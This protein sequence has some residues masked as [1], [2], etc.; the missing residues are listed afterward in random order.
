MIPV[1]QNYLTCVFLYSIYE[2]AQ[3]FLS[4]LNNCICSQVVLKEGP[5]MEGEIK[6][7]L[8]DLVN[9]LK[10]DLLVSYMICVSQFNDSVKQ[11][12]VSMS[13]V[14]KNKNIFI[15]ATCSSGFWN[16]YVVD[17]VMT[18]YPVREQRRDDFN[19]TFTLPDGVTCKAYKISDG[20]VKNPCGL[21]RNLFGLSP[22]LDA[23]ETAPEYRYGNCAEAESLSH[24][25]N[26]NAE[27][28]PSLR[29]TLN[30]REEVITH[31]QEVLNQ[32]LKSVHFEWNNEFYE[33]EYYM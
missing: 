5:A 4:P 11:Y 17:A 14:K 18:Y 3:V 9:S 2:K 12:G 6:E 13:N 16:N 30:D 26:K 7:S 8:K 21:C 19:G 15:G 23:D 20:T 27:I 33:P 31:V 1:R 24:L 32:E 28:T 10:S 22:Q 25:L 29:G